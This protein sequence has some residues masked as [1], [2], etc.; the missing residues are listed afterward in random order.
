MGRDWRHVRVAVGD[1][2]VKLA[3]RHRR[4]LAY[5]GLALTM[6]GGLYMVGPA[7]DRSRCL[8]SNARTV[9]LRQAF[10][11]VVSGFGDAPQL[12]DLD[13]QVQRKLRSGLP[14]RKCSKLIFPFNRIL[15]TDD[16]HTL[17]VGVPL[18]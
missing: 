12:V 14:L 15:A 10:H 7:A 11:I 3:E 17:A 13:R 8:S 16:I 9:E 4:L 18:P 6:A 5:V 2:A 1:G